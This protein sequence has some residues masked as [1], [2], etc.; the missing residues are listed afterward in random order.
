MRSIFFFLAIF[1][2]SPS[3][4]GEEIAV[5][6][7]LEFED[8]VMALRNSLN[9][10]ILRDKEL[11]EDLCRYPKLL[12]LGPESYLRVRDRSC[13][14]Q[15]RYLGGILYPALLEVPAEV[16]LISPL[17]SCNLLQ[18]YGKSWVVIHS[19]YLEYYLEH[20]RRCFSL[21]EIR[22]KDHYDLTRALPRLRSLLRQEFRLLL[23]PDPI[24]VSK[25]GRAFIR[26]FLKREKPH[27]IDLIGIS[28]GQLPSPAFLP[29][30][31]ARTVIQA[32]EM[33]LSLFYGGGL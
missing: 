24:L 16:R 8:T 27:G 21:Q 7:D 10:I 2:L 12:V 17:P 33:D 30:I 18:R 9:F 5:V 26:E 31:Y 29:E 13:P 4:W 3:S 11:R 25:K 20:L 22:I 14:G 6:A 28:E 15:K 23:L 1:L 19:R 32:L